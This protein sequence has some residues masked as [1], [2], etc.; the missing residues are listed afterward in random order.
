MRTRCSFLAQGVDGKPV[1]RGVKIDPE[2]VMG[3]DQDHGLAVMALRH[4]GG[5]GSAR[6]GMEILLDDMR[7][8]LSSVSHGEIIGEAPG[9]ICMRE[10]LNNIGEF[11]RDRE[12]EISLAAVHCDETGRITLAVA[13]DLDCYLKGSSVQRLTA[14]SSSRLGG[15]DSADPLLLE[16]DAEQAHCFLFLDTRET[17]FVGADFI[18]LSLGRFCDAPD[19]LLRQIAMRAQRNGLEHAPSLLYAFPKREK[20]GFWERFLRHRGAG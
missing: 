11:L 1:D 9:L 19:M 4:H 10:S 8:N 18:M 6:L 5:G 20:T 15:Q 16:L 7:Q 17:E 12:E 14:S 13:G 3:L 2:V